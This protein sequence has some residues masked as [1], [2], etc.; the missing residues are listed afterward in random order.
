MNILVIYSN[1][2]QLTNKELN[3][4][5]K[6]KNPT[7]DCKYSPL[8]RQFKQSSKQILNH[9]TLSGFI[10]SVGS[11]ADLELSLRYWKRISSPDPLTE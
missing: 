5:L 6:I 9:H 4:G 7:Y 3:Q 8:V 11:M 2:K 10:Y 1:L